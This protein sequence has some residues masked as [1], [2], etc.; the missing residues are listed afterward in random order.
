MHISRERQPP[1]WLLKQIT[2]SMFPARKPSIDSKHPQSGSITHLPASFTDY[3]CR[4]PTMFLCV[5][6][7]WCC[8]AIAGMVRYSRYP[9]WARKLRSSLVPKLRHRFSSSMWVLTFDFWDMV[10]CELSCADFSVLYDCEGFGMSINSCRDSVSPPWGGSILEC[11]YESCFVLESKLCWTSVF[12]HDT[13]VT[14]L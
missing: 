8:S 10:D 4:P 9:W 3:V 1:T 7:Y 2:P 11:L 14:Y 5:L 6:F 13:T 12:T